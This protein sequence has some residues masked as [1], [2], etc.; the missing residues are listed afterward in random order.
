MIEITEP[1]KYLTT[2]EVADFTGIAVETL[3]KMRVKKTGM[4]YIKIGASVYYDKDDT[5]EWMNKQ[6]I[7]PQD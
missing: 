4:P 2:Q 7:N 6:K 1:K 5:I 3:K